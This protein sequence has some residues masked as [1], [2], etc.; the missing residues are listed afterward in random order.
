MQRHLVGKVLQVQNS[1]GHYQYISLVCKTHS[2]SQ[3]AFF[4][5]F[6]F[7]IKMNSEQ[8]RRIQHPPDLV[9]MQSRSTDED[10]HKFVLQQQ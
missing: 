9:A 10:T 7:H 4:E 1:F 2:K 5:S 8:E 3:E 6:F